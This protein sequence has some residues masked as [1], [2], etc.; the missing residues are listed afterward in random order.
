M[1]PASSVEVATVRGTPPGDGAAPL[2]TYRAVGDPLADAALV[3]LGPAST[4]DPEALARALQRH[5][6]AGGSACRALLDAAHDVPSWVDFGRMV[7]ALHR[8]EAHALLSGLSLLT[9]SL[10][11]SFASPESALV[12]MGAGR[13]RTHPRRRLYETARFVHEIVVSGGAPPGS[14]A[15]RSVLGVRLMHA[16]VRARIRESGRWPAAWEC[17]ISQEATVGTLTTFSHVFA[18]S[19][20][21]LGVVFTPAE[22]SAQ[23]HM[24][25]WIGHVL[26]IEGPLLPSSV[27]AETALYSVLA[28]RRYAPDANSRALA[29]GLLNAMA[30]QPPFHLPSS[31]L[32][33]LCRRNLGEGLADAF[34]LPRSTAW[35]A[36]FA[37]LATAISGRARVERSVPFTG[38]LARHVGRRLTRHFVARGLRTE[39]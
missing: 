15:H 26:G 11:E 36:A 3:E 38:P 14:P 20:G 29:H 21:N 13:L 16:F 12:L 35:E 32:F 9:G 10:I 22:R 5:A 8:S 39:S 19:M 23:Q 18:R 17:P 7:P 34:E 2:A 37:G 28:A 6:S 25:R 1:S 24:W 4:A 33:A 31:A 30:R 27:E